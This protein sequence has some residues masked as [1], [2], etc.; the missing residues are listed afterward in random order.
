MWE[1]AVAYNNLMDS[2][3]EK[4]SSDEDKVFTKSVHNYGDAVEQQARE[5]YAAGP[6]VEG[7]PPEGVLVLF[8]FFPR[9]NVRSFSVGVQE[10]DWM[11][12]LGN[13]P[14]GTNISDV[15]A[16]AVINTGGE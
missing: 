9:F 11:D 5:R 6:W 14:F 8:E 15:K 13:E 10:G 3:R 2:V 7:P 1:R 4:L 12:H 16:H